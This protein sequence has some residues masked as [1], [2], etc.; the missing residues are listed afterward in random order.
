MLPLSYLTNNKI[1]FKTNLV[2]DC[3]VPKGNLVL[4]RHFR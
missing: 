1:V 3:Q 4:I 2:E